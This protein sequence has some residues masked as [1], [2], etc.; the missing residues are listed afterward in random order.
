MT[1]VEKM[2]DEIGDRLAILELACLSLGSKELFSVKEKNWDTENYG[3][4]LSKF[5]GKTARL[6]MDCQNELDRMK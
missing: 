2:L 5:L 4:A 1:E 3:Y 6:T